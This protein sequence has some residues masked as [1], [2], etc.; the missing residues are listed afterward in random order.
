MILTGNF[1]GDFPQKDF[2]HSNSNRRRIPSDEPEGANGSGALERLLP[3]AFSL[4]DGDFSQ[5]AGL[6]IGTSNL[7]L[8]AGFESDP[9][10]LGV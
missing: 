8:S 10:H 9:G 7:K 6:R 5:S 4:R 2:C 1:L 3:D